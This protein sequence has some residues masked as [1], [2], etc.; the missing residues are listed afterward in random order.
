MLFDNIHQH[1]TAI[2]AQTARGD[3]VKVKDLIPWLC[4]NLM[5]D[6]RKELF[7]QNVTM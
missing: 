4:K 2:P 1:G 7:V 3:A 5:K 6:S